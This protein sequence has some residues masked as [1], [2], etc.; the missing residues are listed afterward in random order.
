MKEEDLT[1]NTS[2]RKCQ[3]VKEV[4]TK[5][6]EKAFEFM[7]SSLEEWKENNLQLT[8]EWLVDNNK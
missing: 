6:V 3:E 8:V 1:H 4:L 7:N 2:W 5:A